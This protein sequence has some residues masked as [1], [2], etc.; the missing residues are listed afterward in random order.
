MPHDWSRAFDGDSHAG[1]ATRSGNDR[2]ARVS[3]DSR[4]VVDGALFIALPGVNSHGI[5]HVAEAAAGGAAAVLVGNDTAPDAIEFAAR[6]LPVYLDHRRTGEQLVGVVGRAWRDAAGWPVVGITGSSGKTS[7]KEMAATLLSPLMPGV[8]A[9]HANYNNELGVPLTLLGA[10]R[11]CSVV[12]CEMGMR[13]AGQIAYLCDVAAPNVG[14]VTT[15]GSAHLELL[16]SEEAIADAKAE[17]FAGTVQAG[18][19][20]VPL[21]HPDLL[22]RAATLPEHLVGFGRD[23]HGVCADEL[24][25]WCVVSPEFD[26]AGGEIS[27]RIETPHETLSAIVPGHGVHHAENLA[28]ALAIAR[29]LGIGPDEAIA[30]AS[31]I[32]VPSG[33]GSLHVVQNDVV[34]MDDSYN[35]NPESMAAAL[36]SLAGRAGHRR[37]AVLG[38]MAELGPESATFHQAVGE[39]AAS[40]GID[41]LVVVGTGADSDALAEGWDRTRPLERTVAIRV[42]TA[43]EFVGKWQRLTRSG[44]AV[45]VKASNSVGLSGAV[46][47]LLDRYEH[48]V[49]GGTHA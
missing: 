22:R 44:D 46:Q 21:R 13:G 47:E 38:T 40:L 25:W 39:R 19:A 42:A 7:T 15:I 28:A 23:A 31:A 33:R 49:G 43:D 3:I 4:D 35:A 36:A 2:Y 1:R 14:V 32:R 29:A 8:V 6:T 11:D 5:E 12:I 24:E 9:S 18:T 45:L 17:I 41:Q 10:P 27:V 34:L 48:R 16:G 20:V 26:G 30:H 37:V